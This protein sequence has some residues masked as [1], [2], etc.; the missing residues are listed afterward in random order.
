MKTTRI[1][2]L[3][4]T[5][6]LVPALHAHDHDHGKKEAGPNGGRVIA[7]VEPH[8]E[9]FV[10]SDRKVQITFLDDD[11]KAIAPAEQTVTVICGDRSSPT[12]LSFTKTGN[13]L[14][15][16]NTLPEGNDIPTVVQIKT[17]PD[18]KTVLEKFN[19]NLDQCPTCK[20][21]EYACICEHGDG[22]KD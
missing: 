14:L 15:S 17:T 21:K 10:T 2:T 22:D 6:A 13:V 16:D 5:L 19:L 20:F 7:S 4:A 3:I 9:F 8:L 18:A 12:K 1:L 11:E